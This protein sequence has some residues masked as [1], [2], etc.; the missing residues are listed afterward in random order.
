MD[1]SPEPPGAPVAVVF[2]G[3]SPF[4]VACARHISLRQKVMLVTRHIDSDL[5]EAVEGQ[6]NLSLMEADLE[7]EGA[8]SNLLKKVYN[9][10]RQVNLN[11]LIFLQRY[12]PP[13]AE[14]FERHCA[15]ELWSIREALEVVKSRK[16]AADHV[17]VLLSS[18]PAAQKVLLDQNLYYHVVKAGQEALTRYLAASYGK[19]RI[20]INAI[21]IGSTVLKER[22]MAYWNSIPATLDGLEQ[23]APIGT[24][25]TSESVGTFF[26]NFILSS[27][28]GVS[29]Q[30][31]DL[32]NGFSFLDGS[33]VARQLLTPEESH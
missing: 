21:R 2:G 30:I 22:A 12:R 29:G 27:A 10:D 28:I 19:D 26:A 14:S 16:A 15:V 5:E 33:Q 11:A 24:L 25:L 13:D 3:R 4:A 20:D 23:A 31:I 18:S 6:A 9:S 1:N 32:D 7:I 17:G 8:T